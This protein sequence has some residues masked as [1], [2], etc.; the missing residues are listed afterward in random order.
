MY[1]LLNFDCYGPVVAIAAPIK[2]KFFSK[3]YASDDYHIFDTTS[4]IS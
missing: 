2:P 4:E 1:F 3:Y